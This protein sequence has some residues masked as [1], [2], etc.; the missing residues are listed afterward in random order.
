MR[1]W[2]HSSHGCRLCST[3]RY[4]SNSIRGLEGVEAY[5][6]QLRAEKP[7]VQWKVRC[8][9]YELP[10]WLGPFVAIADLTRRKGGAS[11]AGGVDDYDEQN[12]L[13]SSWCSRRVVTKQS[14]AAYQFSHCEDKTIAG[15]WKP[16]PVADWEPPPFTKLLLSV[17]LVLPDSKARDDYM[18]QQS[19][20]VTDHGQGDHYAEFSTSIHVNG[21][22]PRLLAV[23]PASRKVFAQQ[24]VVYWICTLLGL[25]V[26]FR[27]W[28]SDNCDEIRVT[29]VKE[30]L[31]SGSTPPASPTDAQKRGN[32]KSWFISSSPSTAQDD[33]ITFR[34]M[35][36]GLRLYTNKEAEK[37]QPMTEIGADSTNTT[38]NDC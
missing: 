29:V 11:S 12:R 5:I 19:Q 23:R 38:P 2:S 20:F 10:W 6:E 18:K 25:T 8:Y 28:F 22:K 36:Q 13:S 14:S 1:S 9:H 4:L 26:P 31:P 16:A 34:S 30:L 21:F 35:M 17:L 3:H 15:V 37:E 27:M 24:R 33:T 32:Y 7:D